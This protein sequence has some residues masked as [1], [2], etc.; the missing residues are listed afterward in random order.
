MPLKVVN[1]IMNLRTTFHAFYLTR[2]GQSEYN[3]VGKIGG[4][5]GLSEH[6]LAYARKLAEFVETKIASNNGV[7]IP[8]R[9][10]TSTLR[11]TKETAQFIEQ[12]KIIIRDEDDPSVE[13][14][15]VQMKPKAWHHL[16]EI[17]AGVC[18]GMTYEEIEEKYPEEFELRKVITLISLVSY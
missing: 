8:A 15:W 6:G 14:E 16:D 7:D 13:Y 2:H 10:W 12:K 18:D 5:S 11:R 4:D 3:E 1:F 9:L 17:Y